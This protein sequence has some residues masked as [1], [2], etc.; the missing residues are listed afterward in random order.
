MSVHRRVGCSRRRTNMSGSVFGAPLSSPTADAVTDDLLGRGYSRRQLLRIAAVF[1]SVG[2]VASVG[3]PV[4]ASGG[5]PDPP[6][7]ART[8]IGANECWTGPMNPG[9][10]AAAAVISCSN[11]YAPTDQRGEFIKAV[12]QVEG[13]P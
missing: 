2:A 9:Q 12:S 5:I 8:R 1:S 7:D 4:W 6:P 11:R 10:A 13:V 3:Q